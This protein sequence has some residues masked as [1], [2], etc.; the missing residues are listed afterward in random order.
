VG[1]TQEEQDRLNFEEDMAWYARFEAAEGDV[2]IS[3]VHFVVEGDPV[4]KGRPITRFR[5]GQPVRTITPRRTR[6]YEQR[7]A[8][9]ARQA[10]AG[11][12]PLAGPIAVS[13]H[14]YRKTAR[15]CDFDNLAKAVT[16]AIQGDIVFADDD[17]VVEAH[18]YKGLDPARP[19]AEVWI[20][21]ISE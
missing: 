14:F 16:D 8:W 10:M 21:T 12:E 18:I 19:R 20:W 5:D 13:M 1:I 17:Q 9:A 11:R 15:R 4:P 6:Q 2:D 3:A 7:V